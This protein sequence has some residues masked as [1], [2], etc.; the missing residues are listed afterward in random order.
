MTGAI[1]LR[2]YTTDDKIVTLAGLFHPHEVA[3]SEKLEALYRTNAQGYF[4]G[5]RLLS[6]ELEQSDS[7]SR[8]GWIRVQWRLEYGGEA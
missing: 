3:D 8:P 6:T 5:L 1:T 4:G 7:T 2:G